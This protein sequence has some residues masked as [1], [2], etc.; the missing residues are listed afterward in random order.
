MRYVRALS[1]AE[2]EE[3][4]RLHRVGTTHRQ[5]S[6]AQAVLLS[7]RGYGREVIAD[8][9]CASVD[10]VSTWLKR[11]E[12]GGAPG[13][14]DLPKSGRPPK[15]DAQ[16]LLVVATAL[17]SP[18]PALKPLLLERLKKG[19]LCQLGHGQ[20]R[21]QAHGRLVPAGATRARASG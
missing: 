11:F 10:T 14:C 4:E 5:R 1:A 8:I 2:R 6:R 9:V 17:E 3:L 15:L 20:A 21:P 18:T 19:H 7:A 12:S 16:A 13:L